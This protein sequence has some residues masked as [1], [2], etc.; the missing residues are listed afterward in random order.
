[1]AYID[2]RQVSLIMRYLT[3]NSD[4]HTLDWQR[5]TATR[6]PSHGSAVSLWNHVHAQL[7][8]GAE[9]KIVR[10]SQD[11]TLTWRMFE[12]EHRW[13]WMYFCTSRVR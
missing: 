5:S 4:D 6:D 12:S 11:F 10:V 1:M 3:L 7:L 9:R 8:L 13:V 2:D